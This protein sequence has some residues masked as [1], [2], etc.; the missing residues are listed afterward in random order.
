MAVVGARHRGF[1]RA[2][3][4]ACILAMAGRPPFNNRLSRSALCTCVYGVVGRLRQLLDSAKLCRGSESG[5]PALADSSLG[6]H[7]IS[8]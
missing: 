4:L 8:D 5:T 7:V 1:S 2:A 6:A 3:H